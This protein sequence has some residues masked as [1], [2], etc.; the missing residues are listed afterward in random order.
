ME[1]NAPFPIPFMMMKTTSGARDVDTGQIAS[2]LNAL[3][4]IEM[5]RAVTGPIASHRNPQLTRPT[6]EERLNVANSTE[7]VVA[8]I[9]N[10]KAYSGM[11]KGGT[12]KGNV[13]IPVP[14]NNKTNLGSLNKAL[15]DGIN[16][17]H[18]EV[19]VYEDS[20]INRGRGASDTL[21]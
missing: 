1:K 12:S 16:V 11:K 17:S 7:A 8:E 13:A 5:K 14:K 6:A 4:T 3:R 15:L 10:D 21:F 18:V 9:P 2:M 19:K 20:P